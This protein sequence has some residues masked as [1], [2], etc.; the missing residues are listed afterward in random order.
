MDMCQLPVGEG[1]NSPRITG[2]L[3]IQP[4]D[5]AASPSLLY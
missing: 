2:S 5:A 4:P 3:A 1:K